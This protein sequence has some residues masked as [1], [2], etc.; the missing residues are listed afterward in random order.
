[1]IIKGSSVDNKL[2][3]IIKSVKTSLQN[4]NNF[5]TKNVD[6][7]T[8]GLELKPPVNLNE[9]KYV[10]DNSSFVAKC[11][12]I[13][14]KDILLNN[15]T[16]EFE[17]Q[18]LTKI[19]S[20]LQKYNTE[21]YNMGVDYYY[22][23]IGAL[24]YIWDTFKNEFHIKQIPIHT[25]K[26]IRVTVGQEQVYVL[27]QQIQSQINYFKILGETYPKNF[28]SI[29]GIELSNC[30]IIGGDNFYLFFSEPLWVQEKDKIF[31]EISIGEKNLNQISNGN[32]PSG[33]LNINLEPQIAAPVTVDAD[34]NTVHEPTREEIISEELE[35]SN[36][37]VSVIFTESNREVKM[38]YVKIENDNY[39]YLMELQSKAE[40]AVLNCYGIPLTRLMIN[41]EKESMNSNK[42][43]SI[44][45]I[46]TLDLKVESQK[47]KL[48]ISE[49]I[50]ELYGI[51]PE[52]KIELPQFTD[53]KQ[54]EIQTII[55][56][57]NNGLINLRQA[58]TN[59]SLFDTNI[60]LND[61]DF[62]INQ[63]LWDY[64]KI[65]GYYDLL[66]DVDTSLLDSID[67]EINTLK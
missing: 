43:Q 62:S 54:I 52:V 47:W 34:G 50:E 16:L 36:G 22:A 15:I 51:A 18:D 61:Y 57:W 1:M 39:N 44:W 24:E 19:N 10:F 25:C 53:K 65:D 14:S 23:G 58:V 40:H 6:T 64:R 45:E 7:S 9:C 46:Y 59:L 31:T 32:I 66:N 17:E 37:G 12:R 27:K 13:L 67:S 60:D 33:I 48:L 3:S 20:N 11:C 28:N 21:L 42:T 55:D 26:I 56:E 5:H 41:T 30:A 8:T 4:S 35:L 2:N 29:D 49:L 63:D 38:D